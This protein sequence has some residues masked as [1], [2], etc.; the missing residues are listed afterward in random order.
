MEPVQETGLPLASRR[1]GPANRMPL[2]VLLAA[3]LLFAVPVAGLVG[4]MVTTGRPIVLELGATQI[5]IGPPDPTRLSFFSHKPA[6]RLGPGMPPGSGP[7]TCWDK[8]NAHIDLGPIGIAMWQ[9]QA[10]ALPPAPLGP[11]ALPGP[12]AS[13]TIP[14]TGTSTSTP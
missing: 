9:C 12:P 7:H 4:W 6:L 3:L 1:P 8:G 11:L 10:Q 5:H 13:P 14:P 2:A